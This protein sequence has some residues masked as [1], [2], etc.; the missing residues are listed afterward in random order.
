M[1]GFFEK[2]SQKLVR[3]SANEQNGECRIWTGSTG[4][5]GCYGV[6][7]VRYPNAPR[8]TKVY[9]HRLAYMI[10]YRV[11]CVHIEGYDVSH[12]CHNSKCINVHHLSLEPHGF[13]NSRQTCVNVG[14]CL[15][16]PDPLPPC[17][18]DLKMENNNISKYN[19]LYCSKFVS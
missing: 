19:C 12:L 17:K 3:N 2:Y 18:I 7:H 14:H 10:C 4:R 11:P 13:N 15:G 9:V 6:I 16:H 8:W 1:E 5:N